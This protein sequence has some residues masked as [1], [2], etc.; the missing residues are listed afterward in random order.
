[1]QKLCISRSLHYKKIFCQSKFTNKIP[2]YKQLHKIN[3]QLLISND[4][5]IG[6][7]L[8]SMG[9]SKAKG[10]NWSKELILRHL[11]IFSNCIFFAVYMSKQG[12]RH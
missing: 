11:C 3:S 6:Y 1:M 7:F 2:N 4:F 12:Q 10:T 8:Q 5:H 9:Q